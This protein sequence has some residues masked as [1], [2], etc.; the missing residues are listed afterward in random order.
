LIRPGIVTN[1]K[2]AAL[3]W[4]ATLLFERLWMLADREGR[5][6]DRPERIRAEAFPY[7]PDFPV[8]KTVR[9]LVKNLF[10]ARYQV[11]GFRLIFVLN[12]KKH[13]H[14]HNHEAASALP[15]PPANLQVVETGPVASADVDTCRDMSSNVSLSLPLPTGYSGGV[16]NLNG[17]VTVKKSSPPV[18]RKRP[19]TER[20][21][22]APAGSSEAPQERKPPT[23]AAPNFWPHREEDVTT[24]RESLR[25]LAVEIHMPPPD[26]EIVLRVLDCGKGASGA[27]IHEVLKRLHRDR[28]RFDSMRSWGLVPLMAGAWFSKAGAA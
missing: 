12:F 17:V 5:L 14:I 4:E 1:E 26:D 10:I 25:A 23:R 27:A 9:K 18:L 16:E 19:K 2:L 21:A 22:A 28:R 20:N 15:A 6:E 11:D 24:V 3:G 7:W 13:Q 8:E